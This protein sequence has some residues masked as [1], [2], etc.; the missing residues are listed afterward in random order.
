M[1]VRMIAVWRKTGLDLVR[2]DEVSMQTQHGDPIEIEVRVLSDD[3][4][5]V[6]MTARTLT[7]RLCQPVTGAPL[8][9][10]TSTQGN[11]R[12]IATFSFRIP[13]SIPAGSYTWDIFLSDATAGLNSVTRLCSWKILE[14][15]R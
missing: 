8:L 3:K 15:S 9:F 11:T 13:T 12:G 6:D 1:K 5:I 10:S 14:T 4:Q 2:A 7:L